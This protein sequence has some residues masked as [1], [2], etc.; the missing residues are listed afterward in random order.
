MLSPAFFSPNG[1]ATRNEFRLARK[2]FFDESSDANLLFLEAAIN[3]VTSKRALDKE[4]ERVVE[5]AIQAFISGDQPK[6]AKGVDG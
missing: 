5:D 1:A 6:N 2:A 4:G 3:Q